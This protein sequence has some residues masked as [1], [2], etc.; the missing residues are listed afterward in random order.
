MEHKKDQLEEFVNTN[1]DEFN[2]LEPSANLWNNINK[3]IE[4]EY[5]P[6]VKMVPLK[7]VLQIAASF[8]I[9][10]GL[11]FSVY[12]SNNNS[13]KVTI[14]APHI[15]SEFSLSNV[16]NELKEVET[17]YTSQVNSKLKKAHELKI[18]DELLEEITFLDEEYKQLK[19][20]AN[21]SVDNQKIIEAMINNYRLKL[22]ILENVLSEFDDTKTVKNDSYSL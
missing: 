11:G 18:D 17:Y 22:Q 19:E 9:V 2:S 5:T 10:I 6:I 3:S 16:S 13:E 8:L 20:E 7:R 4:S 21:G 14:A 15:Q 1:H 12:I